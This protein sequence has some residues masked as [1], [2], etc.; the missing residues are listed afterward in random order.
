[1]HS[2]LYFTVSNVKFYLERSSSVYVVYVY[3]SFLLIIYSRC[4]GI[5]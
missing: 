5:D 1:M 2:I 4:F 3:V